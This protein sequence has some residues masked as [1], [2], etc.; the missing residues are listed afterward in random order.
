LETFFNT[1]L[2][3]EYETIFGFKKNLPAKVVWNLQDAAGDQAGRSPTTINPHP[4]LFYMKVELLQPEP[5]LEFGAGGRCQDMRFGI[6]HFGTFDFDNLGGPR[7]VKLGLVGTAETLSSLTEWLEKCQYEIPG[8]PNS[9]QPRLYPPFPGYTTNHSFH[10]RL[11]WSTNEFRTVTIP[12]DI[13]QLNKFNDIV[14]KVVDLYVEEIDKAIEKSGANVILCAPPLEHVKLTTFITSDENTDE[15]Q[16][17]PEDGEDD[18]KSDDTESVLYD[19]HDL[20]KAKS[21]HLRIPLQIVLPATYDDSKNAEQKKLINRDQQDEAT[22]AWNLLTALYYKARGIPWR[23]KRAESD[24]KTCYIG[25]SFFRTLDQERIYASSAQVFNQLGEGVIVR[26]GLAYEDKDD[27]TL[28]L[29]KDGAYNLAKRALG[30]FWDEHFHYPARVVVHKTSLFTQDE[31]DGF[32]QLFKEKSI[33]QI[34]C[35]YLTESLTRLFRPADYPP[36]RGTLWHLENKRAVLYTRGS[37]PFY[38]TYPGQY[39]PRSLFMNCDRAKR[40]VKELARECLELTKMNWN[41][42]RFDGQLPITLRAARQVGKILKYLEGE[43]TSKV[44]QSY[45]FYM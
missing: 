5:D 25:V 42:T 8:K 35:L 22:R 19:F 41:N 1:I 28:H 44:S 30:A 27:R 32:T 6:G 39:P 7:Q 45:R 38:E 37:V 20:L 15:G 12:P 21:L 9:R 24:V 11:A 14:E 23:M 26:G 33:G 31:H 3:T 16:P 2:N 13:P 4:G 10:S 29:D 36:L 17:S 18:S 43:D 34:D 40:P